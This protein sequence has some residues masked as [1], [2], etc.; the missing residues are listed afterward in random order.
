MEGKCSPNGFRE[1]A[2]DLVLASMLCLQRCAG[3]PQQSFSIEDMV[4]ALISIIHSEVTCL[5]WSLIDNE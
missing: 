4:I 3:L 5:V 1:G 2:S